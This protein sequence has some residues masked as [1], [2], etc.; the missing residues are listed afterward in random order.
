M[1]VEKRLR[2]DDGGRDAPLHVAGA[3]TVDA[4]VAHLAAE[5]IGGPAVAGLDH[6]V[7]AVEMH[8]VAGTRAF[9]PGDHVPA[10]IPVAVGGRAVGADHLDGEATVRRR[11]PRTSQISRYCGPAD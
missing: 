5:G 10:R 6:V 2:R 9:D 4:A 3:A 8:A 11:A 1:G 7:M